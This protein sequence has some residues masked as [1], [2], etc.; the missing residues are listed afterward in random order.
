MLL[1]CHIAQD[2]CQTVFSNFQATF[3]LEKAKDIGRAG[4]LGGILWL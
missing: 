1:N 3:M 4:L 2:V